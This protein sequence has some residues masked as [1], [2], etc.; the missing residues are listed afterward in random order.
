[1]SDKTDIEKI[2]KD[3]IQE[4]TGTP[5]MQLRGL[6]PQ[7]AVANFI[8]RQLAAPTVSIPQQSTDV[9][10]T[11]TIPNAPGL[12][13]TNEQPISPPGGG[14]GDVLGE[15]DDII[16]I[17]SGAAYYVNFNAVIGSPV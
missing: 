6:T 12:I 14:G 16:V 5:A 15:V 3:T 13:N 9:T 8:A 11:I 17:F 2:A 1:M 10:S 4:V 7:D